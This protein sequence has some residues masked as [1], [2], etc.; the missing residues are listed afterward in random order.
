MILASSLAACGGASTKEVVE[1]PTDLVATPKA[2]DPGLVSL[3]ITPAQQLVA[4]GAAG[5]LAARVRIRAGALPRSKAPPVNLA[6]VIDTSGSM[7]GKAI[8]DARAA[9]RAVVA[10][11]NDGDRLAIVVFHSVAEVL[12]PSTVLDPERRAE[13]DRHIDR[14]VARGTTDLQNGLALGLQQVQ[15]ALLADGINRIVLVSDGVPNEAGHVMSYAQSA[16]GQGIAITALGLG[17]QYDETLLAAVAQQTGGTFHFIESS[18]QVAGLLKDQVLALRQVVARNASLALSP[19]PGVTITGVLGHQAQ[20]S[21]RAVYVPLGELVQGEERDLYLELA[22][23]AHAEEATVELADVVLT[24]DDA[25]VSA[26]RLERRAF[27]SVKASGDRQAIAASR[28]PEVVR[29]VER[30]RA[31]AATLQVISI[32]RSGQLE[33]ARTRLDQAEKATRKMARELDDPELRRAAR[34]MAE[35]REALPS[36]APPAP[37]PGAAGAGAPQEAPAVSPR[38]P[39]VVKQVHADAVESLR[40]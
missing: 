7:E 26:G 5:T 22:I 9:A 38:A 29:G 16:A 14:M 11:L 35:L 18:E 24:F 6:L 12:A 8:E 34:S 2:A 31:S 4:A 10:G 28:D 23:A 27:A 17:L 21:G 20:P 33:Q 30:A 1:P 25:V 3:E 39:A 32:A 37:P 15:G 19:G 40:R 36:L 13:L